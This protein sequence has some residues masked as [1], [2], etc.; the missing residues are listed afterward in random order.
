M[1]GDRRRL[2]EMKKALGHPT[3]TEVSSIERSTPKS[4]KNLNAPAR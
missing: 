2:G 1:T 3:P 4:K